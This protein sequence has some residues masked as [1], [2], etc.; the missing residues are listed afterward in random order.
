MQKTLREI[1]N[2][3]HGKLVGG[4]SD[5]HLLVDGVST[6]TRTLERNNLYVPLKGERFDGHAFWMDAVRAGLQPPSG[7]GRYLSRRI[8]PSH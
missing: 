7:A 3:T 2:W 8:L 4:V 1:T 6:D 5:P